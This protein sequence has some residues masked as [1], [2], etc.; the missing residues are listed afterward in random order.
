MKKFPVVMEAM[1]KLPDYYVSIFCPVSADK[2]LPQKR[3]RLILIGSKKSFQ[4]R[5]PE[6]SGRISL[7][8]ILENEPDVKIP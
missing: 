7:R 1:S 3:D 2:F 8:D 5:E 6:S 4:W